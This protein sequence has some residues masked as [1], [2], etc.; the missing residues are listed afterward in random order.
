LEIAANAL[1]VVTLKHLATLYEEVLQQLSFAT[2]LKELAD[3]V[4]EG[5]EK[6]GIIN[7][8]QFGR[9]FA[10]EVDGFGNSFTIDDANL[11]SLLSLPHFGYVSKTEEIY[12]N[13]R[14]FVLSH[15]NPYYFS[16]S[17]GKGIGGPSYGIGY[18]SPLSVILQAQTS[19]SDRE[20]LECLEILK[21]VSS[22]W[23]LFHK[24]FH[25]NSA[26]PLGAPSSL[27]NLQFAQLILTLSEERP[28]LLFGPNADNLAPI[29]LKWKSGDR[30][31]VDLLPATSQNTKQNA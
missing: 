15:V 19:N 2:K 8:P 29:K 28:Y 14:A 25:K 20:I 27:V 24:Y 17:V 4:Q 11:P 3:I 22:G 30:Q 6:Y 16:G 7:H 18:I 31:I 10:Y 12:V 5:I 13:T 23:G 9:I 26:L 1:L 21:N